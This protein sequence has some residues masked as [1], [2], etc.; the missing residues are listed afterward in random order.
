MRVQL[1]MC[2]IMLWFCTTPFSFPTVAFA[3]L[4]PGLK[5]NSSHVIFEKQY[6]YNFG[7][8]WFVCIMKLP[9]TRYLAISC[10][11]Q[12][13]ASV[14]N[15]VFCSHLTG[16]VCHLLLCLVLALLQHSYSQNCS[17]AGNVNCT[18]GDLIIMTIY[19][20]QSNVATGTV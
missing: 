17:L 19:Y 8:S 1:I 7:T 13:R 14:I 16:A 15:M 3:L 11:T 4:L 10:F 12:A 18:A 5:A 20:S 9:G 6:I 2:I